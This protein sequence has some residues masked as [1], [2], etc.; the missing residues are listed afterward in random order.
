MWDAASAWPDEQCVDPHSGSEP[1]KAWA[2]GVEHVNLTPQPQ[3]Q[4]H[5]PTILKA[6]DGEV[7]YA[8][9]LT[10]VYD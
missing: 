2:M 8:N 10:F 3:G 1:A 4:P 7:H 6:G 9:F 5:E